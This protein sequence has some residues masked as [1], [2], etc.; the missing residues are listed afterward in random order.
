MQ[1]FFT[2][3]VDG[4]I[5]FTSR[6][7][8]FRSLILLV[9]TALTITLFI[10]EAAIYA[11]VFAIAVGLIATTYDIYTSIKKNK[12]LELIKAKDEA[13]S[14]EIEALLEQLENKKQH[15]Q[16]LEEKVTKLQTYQ[17]AL[18]RYSFLLEALRNKIATSGKDNN[19][20]KNLCLAYN[21]IKTD[22]EKA[23]DLRLSI[24]T[25]D[26]KMLKLNDAATKVLALLM[27]S[28]S[29]EER[30]QYIS[31]NKLEF[32][33]GFST[34]A[35]IPTENIPKPTPAPIVKK[36][37]F[38][39]SV[40]TG[41]STGLTVFGLGLAATLGIAGLL[42]TPAVI[43][44]LPVTVMLASSFALFG[45]ASVVAVATAALHYKFVLPRNQE[46][47]KLRNEQENNIKLTKIEN[48]KKEKEYVM[49]CTRTNMNFIKDLKANTLKQEE[50][51]SAH[52]AGLENNSLHN[53][54]QT[55]YS[56]IEQ[57]IVAHPKS[58]IPTNKIDMAP[59][60]LQEDLLFNHQQPQEA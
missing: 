38:N 16:K 57:H 9:L 23:R 51:I 31:D 27:N 46:L 13:E 60:P 41:L 34:G 48:L 30:R 18:A 53:E 49:H 5:S 50:N 11:F 43:V 39:D 26:E 19:E 8:Q 56:A 33:A 25:I 37:F 6:V 24:T 44:T 15:N 52:L 40:K 2:T 22:A 29:K 14:K 36:E 35:S 21:D 54:K 55:V 47:N 20:Q 58:I 59:L 32:N 10:P 7:N 3:I 17:S 4:F 45:L 42:L 1:K 12:E 28:S